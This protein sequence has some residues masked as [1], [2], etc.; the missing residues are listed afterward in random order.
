MAADGRGYRDAATPPKPPTIDRFRLALAL[1]RPVELVSV[2]DRLEAP[3]QAGRTRR[4]IVE[5][6]RLQRVVRYLLSNE[7]N[8]LPAPFDLGEAYQL[9][10]GM[11]IHL[12]APPKSLELPSIPLEVASTF[13]RLEANEDFLHAQAVMDSKGNLVP[14]FLACPGRVR[15][16]L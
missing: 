4:G 8:C 2:F 11:Q 5:K 1:R 3:Y 14:E 10:Y 6:S 9:A 13:R 15:S 12:V 16:R 7:R